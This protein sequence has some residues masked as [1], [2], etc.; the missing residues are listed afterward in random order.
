VSPE[1][2]DRSM[3]QYELAVGLRGE[4][5]VPGAYQTLYKALEMNPDNAKAHLLLGHMFLLDRE[6]NPKEMDPK[7]EHHFRE[8]L[9]I[10]ESVAAQVEHD[11]KPSAYNGIGVL[12]IHQKR[13]QAAID[14]L[15][16]AVGDLFNREAYMAWGNLGWAQ[17]EMKDYAKAIDSLGRALKLAPQFC[18]GYFR[19]GQAHL[20]T[21]A[22]AKAEEALTR[23]VEAHPDCGKFQ[24][25]WNLRG[26]ARMN[27]GSREDAR[28]DFER[29]V[30]ISTTTEA[31]KSCA[32]Y[33]EATY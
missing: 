2:V 23:A 11:L 17:I 22:Y 3:K 16:K 32:R 21:K 20:A 28:A 25:A 26:E 19:L 10:Q 14:V 13:Y 6:D 7:A 15:R 33:L 29:C 24:D 27:L 30:E 5:N 9:R 31:G 18:V 1:D 4:G 12:H 8:V